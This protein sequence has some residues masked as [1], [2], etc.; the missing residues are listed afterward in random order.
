MKA[1]LFGGIMLACALPAYCQALDTATTPEPSTLVML[2]IGVAG[3][4]LAAWR[5]SKK[6]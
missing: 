1:I 3:I 2:S 4:G 5:R 6:K